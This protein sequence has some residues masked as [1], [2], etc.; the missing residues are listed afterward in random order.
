MGMMV[1]NGERHWTNHEVE[2]LIALWGRV[3]ARQIG[4]ELNRTKL[5]IKHYARRLGLPKRVVSPGSYFWTMEQRR[6]H[7]KRME[8]VWDRKRSF[9]SAA[10][11]ASGSPTNQKEGG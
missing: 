7:S 10:R 3:T 6:E 11:S 9:S 4:Q 8:A 5:A 2:R 1:R